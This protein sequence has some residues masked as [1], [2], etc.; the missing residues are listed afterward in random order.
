[1]A[2][3][4]ARLSERENAEKS[5]PFERRTGAKSAPADSGADESSENWNR[6]R[7]SG[8]AEAKA[9][10]RRRPGRSEWSKEHFLAMMSHEIRT[11]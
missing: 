1:M 5:H 7:A 11:P 10:E 4:P 6:R 9:N 3:S 2:P 8:A